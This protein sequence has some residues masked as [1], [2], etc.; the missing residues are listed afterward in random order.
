MADLCGA[1]VVVWGF[2]VSGKN[3]AFG[4]D[5]VDEDGGRVDHGDDGVESQ[6]MGGL[7]WRWS[8]VDDHLGATGGL[9]LRA[10]ICD[11]RASDARY[12]VVAAARQYGSDFSECVATGH[13]DADRELLGNGSD[14]L[15][16]WIRL[17]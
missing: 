12:D 13:F 9:V 11:T 3:H 10:G 4:I 2:G 5:I 17:Q 8:S 6:R 1:S 15:V 7:R 16:A 14:F